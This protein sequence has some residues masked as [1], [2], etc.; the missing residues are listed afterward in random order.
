MEAVSG[1]WRQDQKKWS[2]KH[3]IYLDYYNLKNHHNSANY[4]QIYSKIFK[5]LL[6]KIYMEKF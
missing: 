5:I 6:I 3:F 4:D 1:N 2:F